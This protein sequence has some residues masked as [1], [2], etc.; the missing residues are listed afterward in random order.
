[1]RSVFRVRRLVSLALFGFVL[2][3]GVATAEAAPKV[4]VKIIVIEAKKSG[5][6]S[7][8]LKALHLQEKLA[9]YG[10]K[11]GRVLDELATSVEPKS[12]VTLYMKDEAGKQR[13]LKVTV[14]EAN[15][16]ADVV[17]L[18]IQAPELNFDGKTNHK[19]GGTLLLA[20]KRNPTTAWFF[21]VTPK[22]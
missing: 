15:K 20:K 3:L 16:K 21:A 14:L 11:G 18:R 9:D 5:S 22:L 8:R 4:A 7:K 17:R 12:S 6:L 1:M 10:Y 2:G 19:K 13:S